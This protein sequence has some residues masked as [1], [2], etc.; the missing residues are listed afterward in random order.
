LFI[1]EYNNHNVFLT[2]QDLQMSKRFFFINEL[3]CVKQ[4]ITLIV[5]HPEQITVESRYIDKSFVFDY[6]KFHTVI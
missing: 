5:I 2:K 4:F 1:G 3:S 6:L